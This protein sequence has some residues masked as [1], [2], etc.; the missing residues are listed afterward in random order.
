[1]PRK[2]GKA[3]FGFVVSGCMC[4][5]SDFLIAW[6]IVSILF[7]CV[8]LCSFDVFVYFVG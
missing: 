7:V 3:K 5:W 2:D 1:M 8:Y 4:G 6:S